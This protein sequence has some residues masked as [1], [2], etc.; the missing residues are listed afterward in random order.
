MSPIADVDPEATAKT[1]RSVGDPVLVWSRIETKATPGVRNPQGHDQF[2]GRAAQAVEASGHD[3]VVVAAAPN[4]PSAGPFVSD[5]DTP[6]SRNCS[7]MPA[8][9]AAA[10]CDGLELRGLV[11][12]GDARLQGGTQR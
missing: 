10:R 1:G 4:L 8:S 2:R 11:G 7:A 5:S 9:R 3:R 6:W 12:G